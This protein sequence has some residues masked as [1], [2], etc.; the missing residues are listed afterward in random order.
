[1]N[2]EDKRTKIMEAAL[3]IFLRDG[4]E[5]ATIQ[6]IAQTAGV[7]KGT[8]YE[9]FSSKEDLFSS[10]VKECFQ[11]FMNELS[12][13][14]AGDGTVYMKMERMCVHHLHIFKKETRFRELMQ[15]DFGKIPEEL[16][17]W[18][19]QLEQEMLDMLEAIM[20]SGMES[21]ELANMHPR[22]AAT[23]IL[24][25]MRFIYT[26]QP[27]K[28]ETMEELVKQ[29]LAMLWSGMGRKIESQS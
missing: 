6:E 25:S 8:T 4:Y 21:G 16:H 18:L 24:H 26:Y 13:A 19:M 20:I 1:M 12:T 10:V 3:D 22:I 17:S 2:K 29:Q 27:K 5:R 7:G 23:T 28:G 9:Y 15:N 11:L 14:L